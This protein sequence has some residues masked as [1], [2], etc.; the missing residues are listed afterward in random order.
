M[1]VIVPLLGLLAYWLVFLRRSRVSREPIP[2]RPPACAPPDGPVATALSRLADRAPWLRILPLLG[3]IMIGL[4]LTISTPLTVL[5]SEQYYWESRVNGTGAVVPYISDTGGNRPAYF[6]FSVGLTCGAALLLAGFRLVYERMDPHLA[7]LDALHGRYGPRGELLRC[8]PA[9][10]AAGD[11]C[12]APAPEEAMVRGPDDADGGGEAG[13]K[14][15]DQDDEPPEGQQPLLR[16]CWCSTGRW[17][18]CC[19]CCCAQSLRQ[20]GRS[21]YLASIPLCLGMPLLGWCAVSIEV[22]VHSF[23]AAA[24]FGCAYLHMALMARLAAARIAGAAAGG[25]LVK[26]SD[27]LSASLKAFF[28]WLVPVAAAFMFIV[29][30][31]ACGGRSGAIWNAYMSAI[32]EWAYAGLLGAYFASLY[33]E[34]GLL[35]PQMD[36]AKV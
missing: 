5:K 18:H 27:A 2:A 19:C 33:H 11:C 35:P 16:P 8:E 30:L 14:P 28:T 21:A 25:P 12:A 17:R 6:P 34:A 32:F 13:K 20:Q 22:F 23:G 1:F 9:E 24:V 29:V 15:P 7:A 10:V 36:D 26:R 31:P 3:A 4:T